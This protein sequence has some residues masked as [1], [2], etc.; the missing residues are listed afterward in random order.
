MAMITILNW[1]TIRLFNNMA[2]KKGWL[3]TAF[4][5]VAAAL[6]VDL[7]LVFP[8]SHTSIFG[9]IIT[10]WSGSMVVPPLDWLATDVFGIQSTAGSMAAG[11]GG[12]VT[13]ATLPP[14]IPTGVEG[15]VTP[16]PPPPVTPGVEQAVPVDRGTSL[17]SL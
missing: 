12:A 4:I 13:A 1:L 6:A 3:S 14:P 10:K 11:G 5:A 7:L 17:E 15:A 16:P 9:G 8:I 2:A